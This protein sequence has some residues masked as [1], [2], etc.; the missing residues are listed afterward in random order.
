MT[1]R[2]WHVIYT[3]AGSSSTFSSTQK[4]GD[5]WIYDRLTNDPSQGPLNE[6]PNMAY[7][8]GNNGV[9]ISPVNGIVNGKNVLGFNEGIMEVWY[10]GSGSGSTGL[11]YFLFKLESPE[12]YYRISINGVGYSSS[13]TSTFR[14][15]RRDSVPISHTNLY[16]NL[17]FDRVPRDS[18]WA[19]I[20][21]YWYYPNPTTKTSLIIRVEG[22]NNDG[23]GITHYGTATDNSPLPDSSTCSIGLGGEGTGAH[24]YFDALR[25]RPRPAGQT[26]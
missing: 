15:Q 20:R 11:L 4:Y 18:K 2:D 13:A 25:L 22:D 7:T 26:F 9:Y 12:R 24:Q 17:F 5:P 14:I 19:F 21:I 6:T 8:Q 16:E 3:G 10:V 23:Q 1:I